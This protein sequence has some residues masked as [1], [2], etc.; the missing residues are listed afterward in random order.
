MIRLALARGRMA[1]SSHSA[2]RVRSGARGRARWLAREVEAVRHVVRPRVACIQGRQAEE[3]L[4]ELQ[5]AH[6]RMQ[7]LGEVPALRIGA[8]DQTAN[9]RT[10]AELRAV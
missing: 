9:P 7:H 2:K 4:A 1:A 3:R 5:Q 6:V 8:Q 10:V